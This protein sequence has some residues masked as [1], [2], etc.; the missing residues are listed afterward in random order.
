M[1]Q[2]LHRQLKSWVWGR[3]PVLSSGSPLSL[4][5]DSQLSVNNNNTNNLLFCTGSFGNNSMA[6]SRLASQVTCW[7]GRRRRATGG[8][9]WTLT[10]TL[11]PPM[12]PSGW[13]KGWRTRCESTPSTASACRATVRPRSRSYQ[14]VSLR[15]RVWILLMASSVFRHPVLH[16][17]RMSEAC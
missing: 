6:S 8:W 9:G 12:K 1:S 11:T 15:R 5:V 13:S 2:I 10:R 16:V 7:R 4:M 14:W 17:W 3:T